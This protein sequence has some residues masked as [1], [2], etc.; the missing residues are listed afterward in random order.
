M[1]L[2]V[3][4]S[5]LIA[6]FWYMVADMS[7]DPIKTWIYNDGFQ[8]APPFDVTIHLIYQLFKFKCLNNP[9]KFLLLNKAY[10]CSYY[11][12]IQTLVTVGYGDL[13]P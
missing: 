8:D 9:K 2:M 7:E 3:L 12:T 1:V 6:C 4:I 10:I 5:H 13:H 11:W